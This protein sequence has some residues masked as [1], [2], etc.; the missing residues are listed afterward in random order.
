MKQLLEDNKE[1]KDK[2]QY[3]FTSIALCFG[4]VCRY[5]L[6]FCLFYSSEI[7]E[8]FKQLK[9]DLQAGQRQKPEWIGF[10]LTSLM[11]VWKFCENVTPQKRQLAF[12]AI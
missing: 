12:R 3:S 1:N 2:K 5:Y 4:N 9:E 11:H 6:G 10:L 7:L 8:R